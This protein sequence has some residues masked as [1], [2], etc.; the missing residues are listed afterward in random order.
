[1]FTSIGRAGLEP[2][3]SPKSAARPLH[4]TACQIAG[5]GLEPGPRGYEP[6][7]LATTLSRRSAHLDSNEGRPG[8]QPGALATELWTVCWRGVDVPSRCA[9]GTRSSPDSNRGLGLERAVSLATTPLEH[10]GPR[11]VR[12]SSARGPNRFAESIYYRQGV[13]DP[14]PVGARVCA[15]SPRHDSNV[16]LLLYRE[17]SWPLDHG[18]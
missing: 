18:K 8:L 1:M 4:W 12:G 13:F 15:E 11:P 14:I 3:L 16:R 17:A 7:G 6:R 9:R 5:P 10:G 2:A